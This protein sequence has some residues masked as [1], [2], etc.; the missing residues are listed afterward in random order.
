MA[1]AVLGWPLRVRKLPRMAGLRE[2]LEY[3]RTVARGSAVDRPWSVPG[4]VLSGLRHR[5]RHAPEDSPL[6]VHDVMADA[7]YRDL[8]TATVAEGDLAPDFTLP[9]VDGEGT[10]HLGSLVALGTV[11]AALKLDHPRIR[12]GAGV[13]L[14]GEDRRRRRGTA[15]DRRVGALD[16]DHLHV[17]VERA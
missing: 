5:R 8:M 14:A 6:G 2:Q 16:G 10:V 12:V 3:M 15:D 7:G 17:V 13:D 1:T 4:Q 9:R 11:Q